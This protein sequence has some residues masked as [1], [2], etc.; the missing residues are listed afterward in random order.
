MITGD[1]GFMLGGLTEFTAAVRHKVDLILIVC[2][3]GGYG[4]E[5]IQFVNRQMIC[6][7]F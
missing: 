7:R 1:G 6:P 4:A 3:D 2:N 5:H